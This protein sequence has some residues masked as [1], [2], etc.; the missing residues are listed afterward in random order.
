MKSFDRRVLWDVF[1]SAVSPGFFSLR[2]RATPKEAK[3][4]TYE[5]CLYHR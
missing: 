3:E 4:A 2:I 1:H 5:D